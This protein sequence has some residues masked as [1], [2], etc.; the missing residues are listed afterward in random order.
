M[1]LREKLEYIVK[2]VNNIPEKMWVNSSDEKDS[3]QVVLLM[4]V[5]ELDGYEGSGERII[6]DKNGKLWYGF[7]SHCSCNGPWESGKKLDETYND[8][9][10]ELL[11]NKIQETRDYSQFKNEYKQFEMEIQAIISNFGDDAKKGIELTYHAAK[12]EPF[13]VEEYL[14][15]INIDKSQ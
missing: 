6:L 8:N 5:Y 9:W 3:D 12:G 15:E 2:N 11:A 13:A 1:E 4:D 10:G 14:K 7:N